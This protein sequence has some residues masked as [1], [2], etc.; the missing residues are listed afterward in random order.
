MLPMIFN[1][2]LW[3]SHWVERRTAP[4][5]E[6]NQLSLHDW[7]SE[8]KN[9]QHHKKV[10]L[11]AFHLN[12]PTLKNFVNGFKSWNHLAK[13]NVILWECWTFEETT[14]IH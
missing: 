4:V 6:N 2:N 8:L 14:D 10:L 11:S 9:K 7:F 5:W 13:P 12:G 3:P 1:S